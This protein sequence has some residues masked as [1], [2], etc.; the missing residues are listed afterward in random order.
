[1][2]RNLHDSSLASTVTAKAGADATNDDKVTNDDKGEL[3]LRRAETP[4]P[5]IQHLQRLGR[6]LPTHR[7][8]KLLTLFP[9]MIALSNHFPPVLATCQFRRVDSRHSDAATMIQLNASTFHTPAGSN[10]HHCDGDIRRCASLRRRNRRRRAII[11]FGKQPPQHFL[12]LVC[13]STTHGARGSFMGRRLLTPPENHSGGQHCELSDHTTS[14]WGGSD[15]NLLTL[16][17]FANGD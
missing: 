3:N 13:A 12:L 14:A 9:P 11:G 5:P 4:R 16:T 8:A 1:M 15:T 6:T 17:I 2:G 7:F 10:V